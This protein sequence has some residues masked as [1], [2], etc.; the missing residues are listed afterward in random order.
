MQSK[1]CL[2]NKNK[3]KRTE[4]EARKAQKNAQDHIYILMFFFQFSLKMYRFVNK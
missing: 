1:K 3:S 4:K 2:R